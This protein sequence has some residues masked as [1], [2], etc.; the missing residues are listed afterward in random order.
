LTRVVVAA[1]IVLLWC[2][3]AEAQIATAPG[4]IEARGFLFPE[5]APNDTTQAI[6]DWLWR[7]EGSLRPASWLQFVAGI[8]LRANTHDQVEDIWRIDWEDRHLRPP[9]I[10]VRRLA[11]TITAGRFTLDV[12]KQLIRWARADVLNP[13]DRFAPRDYLNVI[14]SEFL[15]VIAAR[16]SVQAGPE[17]FEAVW[18][19]QL[20]PSR[21]PLLTQRWTVLPAEAADVSILDT[22]SRFPRRTQAGGRWRHIGSR[23]EA[24][25]TYFDGFNHHPTL[26]LVPLDEG[27]RSVSLTRTFPRLRTGGAELAIPTRWITFK[28]EAAWFGHPHSALDDY[29]LY[30]VEL[31]RQIGEWLL[32][33]GYA[34]EVVE[35]DR[36]PLAFDPER[37]L[38]RSILWRASYT[39]DPRRTIAIEGV[40]RQTGKGY[41]VKGEYSQAFGEFWRINI[42]PVVLGGDEDDFLGRYRS[43]SHLAIALRL[44]F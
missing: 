1:L 11:T 23:F 32:T 17:T 31:E 16:A 35:S 37:G 24:G 8:D 20:T 4:F 18:V 21:M 2:A 3:A 44:S 25:L 33:A 28:G 34:G 38:T 15:P 12:G 14:G 39:V 27:G 41:Y 22:G 26:E 19:P 13:I 42:T 9:R 6:S 5:E 43:N 36:I 10:S 40:A 29:G 30:V 7:Q